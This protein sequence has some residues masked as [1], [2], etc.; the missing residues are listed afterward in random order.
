MVSTHFLFS[1]PDFSSFSGLAVGAWTSIAG[2]IPECVGERSCK[3]LGE[4][5][6][7][8]DA[9]DDASSSASESLLRLGSCSHE[10]MIRGSA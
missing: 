4:S 10:G 1:I 9:W 3:P 7:G 5:A 8:S 2:S 6:E